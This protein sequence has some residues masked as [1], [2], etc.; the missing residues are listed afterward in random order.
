MAVRGKIKHGTG[1]VEVLDWA[2]LDWVV[3]NYA[4]CRYV[5]SIVVG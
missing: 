5:R 2:G 4:P 1:G 3:V